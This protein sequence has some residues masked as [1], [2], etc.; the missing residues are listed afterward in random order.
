MKLD[1]V[2]EVNPVDRSPL[3]INLKC[4]SSKNVL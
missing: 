1:D 3:R 2:V 4:H